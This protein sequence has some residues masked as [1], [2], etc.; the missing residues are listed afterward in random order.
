MGHA[1]LPPPP[2]PPPP[3]PGLPPGAV[4]GH[5]IRRRSDRAIIASLA[6]LA[7]L[8]V[9]TLLYF[10][11]SVFITLFSSILIAFALEPPVQFLVRKVR[12]KRALAALLVVVL[13][14]A[15][16]YGIA[17][18]AYVRFTGF[19][20]EIPDLVEKVRTAP[21][22]ERITSSVQDVTKIAEEA[23]RRLSTAPPAPRWGKPPAPVV[24]SGGE[25]VARA[26]YHWLGSVS[27]V[28]FPLSFI[29][30]FV[31]FI[32]ADKEPITRRTKALF[33][34]EYEAVAARIL[35]DVEKMM[36][37]FLLGNGLVAAILSATTMA[38]FWLVGLPY[39]LVLGI[40]SGAMS[41]IPYLGLPLALL[42]PL[43]LA[44]ITFDTGLPLLVLAISVTLFHVI[45]ANYLVPRLV[46]GKMHINAVVSTFALLFFGWMWGGMGLL[47]AI[48]VVAVLKCIL[49]NF[50]STRPF[51]LWM[52]D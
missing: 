26:V 13:A 50:E 5:F 4:P 44:L 9:V 18:G 30:F 42:P 22:V 7:V 38:V 2:E 45:A 40:L 33:P 11:A 39:W 10:A 43:F 20:S 31:Y 24:V 35:E 16:L 47:L 1:H 46:G 41:T 19:L 17:Y 29:P 49:E 34:D 12:I 3:P 15:I 8:G 6:T 28:V 14:V 21:L 51:A 25:P 32:L 48:P 23:G 37:R 52:G 36:R 27:S